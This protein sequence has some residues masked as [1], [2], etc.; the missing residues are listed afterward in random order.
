MVFIIRNHFFAGEMG[1]LLVARPAPEEILRREPFESS[2]LP[3]I[4]ALQPQPVTSTPRCEGQA[5]Q[6]KVPS[7]EHTSHHPPEAYKLR[8]CVRRKRILNLSNGNQAWAIARSLFKSIHKETR[9]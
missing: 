2:K 3:F 5:Y 8:S 6:D 4:W 9:F 7:I 1:K